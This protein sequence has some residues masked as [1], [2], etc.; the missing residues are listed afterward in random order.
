MIGLFLEKRRDTTI[1][2]ATLYAWLGSWQAV[3]SF[4]ETTRNGFKNVATCWGLDT[5]PIGSH[6]GRE[7][8]SPFSNLKILFGYWFVKHACSCTSSNSTQHSQ[9]IDSI[10]LSDGTAVGLKR[11]SKSHHPFEQEIGEYFSS[12]PIV[13]DPK[14]HCVPLLEILAVPDDPDVIVIVMPLLR[15]YDHPRF[16]T[17]GE[18]IDCIRQLFEVCA[19]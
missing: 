18:A 3:K 14:N 5:C 12:D 8:I 6:L 4:G 19:P 10:R 1:N 17:Y 11:V 15:T 2:Y 7:R 16:D 13:N 9:L